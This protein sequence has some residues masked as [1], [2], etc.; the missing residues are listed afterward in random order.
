MAGI[1]GRHQA[2]QWRLSYDANMTR[3]AIDPKLTPR[4]VPGP[5]PGT[6]AL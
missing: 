5:R 6:L 1:Y 3:S 4:P 2:M